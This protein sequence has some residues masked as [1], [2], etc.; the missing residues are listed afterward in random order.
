MEKDNE[1]QQ[2]QSPPPEP[3]PAKRM[4]LESNEDIQFGYQGTLYLPQ[5]TSVASLE[6]QTS[7]IEK[8]LLSFE[9]EIRQ[10]EKKVEESSG[11]EWKRLFFLRSFN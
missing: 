7:R 2:D 9:D 1:R 3:T 6:S 8:Q 10:V 4:K 11:D 5:S